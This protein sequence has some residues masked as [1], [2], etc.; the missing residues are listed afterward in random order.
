MGTLLNAAMAAGGEMAAI[1]GALGAAGARRVGPGQLL[2]V[3]L[4]FAAAAAA[5]FVAYGRLLAAPRAAPIA[6]TPARVQRGT[7]AAAVST[8]G[9]VVSNRQSKLAMQVAGRLVDVPVQL[10]D[11]V[12]AGQVLAKVD[13]APLQLKL[14]DAQTNLQTAQVKL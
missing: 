10:G 12:K 7:V 9:S 6:G 11:R 8:T 5:G 13:A 14:Q 1:T 3:L 2:V 4:V